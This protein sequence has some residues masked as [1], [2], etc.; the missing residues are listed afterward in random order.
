MT[1]ALAPLFRPMAL[2]WWQ[3]ALRELSS[4]N[5]THADIPYIVHRIRNLEAA[6]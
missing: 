6:S 2:L 5:P 1:R 4:R 3:W